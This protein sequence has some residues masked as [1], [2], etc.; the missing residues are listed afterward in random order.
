MIC[1]PICNST[2]PY[3]WGSKNRYKIY[4]CDECTHIFA[5]LS[6]DPPL[7][8]LEG[9]NFRSFFTHNLMSSDKAYYHHLSLGEKEGLHTNI[10]FRIIDK[11]IQSYNLGPT[12]SWLDVGC[13]SGFIVK[14][15]GDRGWNAVGIE[16]G[17]WGQIAAKE[18]KLN[19][20]KGF[21]TKETFQTKF[22]VISATDVLEHQANPIE[23]IKVIKFYLKPE[24]LLIL[25]LPFADSLFAN[26]FKSSWS[27]IGP[28]T[29]C[30]YF[31]NKSFNL[32]AYKT[33]F[34]VIDK[35]QYNSTRIPF[36]SRFEL[37][38]KIFD[39]LLELNNWGDQV[40][41]ILKQ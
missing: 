5:D 19:I 14:Q 24:G 22:D 17:E 11:L 3:F 12:K 39:S 34:R 21:L 33:E 40:V 20:V 32:L 29:H 30:Q 13:G 36:L 16:P 37:F 41:F 31:T 28:P 23:F 27:M 8:N 10:T 4:K 35:I 18:K 1:C 9:D 15:M 26:L 38:N 25:S 6:S 2:T 7:D